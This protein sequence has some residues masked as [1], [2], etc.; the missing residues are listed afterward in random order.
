MFLFGSSM[1]FT[2]KTLRI[3]SLNWRAASTLTVS[4]LKM[5][6]LKAVVITDFCC[7]TSD[8]P[9]FLCLQLHLY[10]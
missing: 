6:P 10:L 1:K 3:N 9:N 8:V 2:S 5:S 7:G 4:L